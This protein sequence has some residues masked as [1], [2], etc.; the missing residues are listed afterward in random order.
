MIL[1]R[2]IGEQEL[3][4][5]RN[6]KNKRFPNNI[7]GSNGTP[8]HYSF[9]TNLLEARKIA[10]EIKGFVCSFKLEDEFVKKLST[11]HRN[12]QVPEELYYEFNDS[13]DGIIY[14][15]ERYDR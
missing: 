9:E 13:I 7:L 14:V 2:P 1:Y 4:A 12:I 8:K 6:S 10:K 15:I 3:Q 11:G 5:I